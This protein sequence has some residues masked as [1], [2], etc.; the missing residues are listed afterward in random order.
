M[1]ELENLV[2][3]E[4]LLERRLFVFRDTRRDCDKFCLICHSIFSLNNYFYKKKP[5][6]H[7]NS[8]G[9]FGVLST[10]DFFYKIQKYK[11]NTVFLKFSSV[12]LD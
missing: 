11:Q 12:T 8:F 2:V 5:N 3:E 6:D 1:V 9:S 4:L 7:E 10:S